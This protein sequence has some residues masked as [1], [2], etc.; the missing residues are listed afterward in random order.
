MADT[1]VSSVLYLL[2]RE[3]CPT[4]TSVSNL[5]IGE[6]HMLEPGGLHV[7]KMFVKTPVSNLKRQTPE[8]HWHAPPLCL[9]VLYTRRP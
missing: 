2:T 6:V 7:G 5:L 4:W 8:K 1:T 3:R 9:R